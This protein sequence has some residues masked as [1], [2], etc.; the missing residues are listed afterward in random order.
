MLGT[1]QPAV[2]DLM[3]GKMSKFSLERLIAFLNALGQDVEISF[4]ER[5]A[6]RE[7]PRLVVNT[8][9]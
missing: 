7:G 1:N 8:A 2:S 5:P 6:E 9:D 3:R 4:R